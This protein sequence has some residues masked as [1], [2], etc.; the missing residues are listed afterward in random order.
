M[1]RNGVSQFM[2]NESPVSVLWDNLLTAA[3][4]RP[5]SPS[6]SPSQQHTLNKKAKH[7]RQPRQRKA[8]LSIYACKQQRGTFWCAEPCRAEKVM[9]RKRVKKVTFS[10]V[11][12]V[13]EFTVTS[14]R[15]D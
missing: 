12:T 1:K 7:H 6:S 9:A 2:D 13:V 11:V 15:W 10:P 8:R 5:P 14:N 3:Q 4:Q